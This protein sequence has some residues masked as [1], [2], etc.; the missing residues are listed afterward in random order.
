MKIGDIIRKALAEGKDTAAIL[1]LVKA[2]HPDAQTTSASVAWYRS[3]MKKQGGAPKAPKA[4]QEPLKFKAGKNVEGGLKLTPTAAVVVPPAYSVKGIKN[5]TGTEGAGYECTLYREGKKVAVAVDH[6][7]GG[8]VHFYWVDK[9]PATVHVYTYEGKP[10]S[11]KGTEEEAM[12]AA[13]CNE[14]GTYQNQFDKSLTMR[15]DMDTVVEDLVNDVMLLKQAEKL[16]K[17]DTRIAYFTGD[18]KLYTV[19]AAP[20]SE[21]I[22]KYVTAHNALVLNGLSTA[23]VVALLKKYQY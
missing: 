6:A 7:D 3:Q 5:I 12:F 14:K 2:E 22:K 9:V 21:N 16:T 17:K 18:G 4:P 15:Y 1:A 19:S 8:P 20:T 23:E 13:F 11:Y 10:H